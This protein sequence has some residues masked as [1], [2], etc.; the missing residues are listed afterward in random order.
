M[1]LGNGFLRGGFDLLL[2][3]HRKAAEEV[4]HGKRAGG[5]L[6]F[7]RIGLCPASSRFSGGIRDDVRRPERKSTAFRDVTRMIWKAGFSSS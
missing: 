3:R 2:A 7:G 1:F 6:A 5:F 4:A